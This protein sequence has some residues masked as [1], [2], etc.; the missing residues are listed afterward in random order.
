VTAFLLLAR[1]ASA[2]QAPADPTLP[3]IENAR[4]EYV[5]GKGAETCPDESFFRDMAA[6]HLGGRDPFTPSAP[7][8][9]TLT[10]RRVR[11]GSYGAV[12]ALYDAAGKHLGSMEEFFAPDCFHVVEIA[13]S[14]VVPWVVP[15]FIPK[16]APPA[17]APVC[18]SKPLPAPEPPP[19]RESRF[20]VWPGEWPMRPLRAPRP[21]TP[22]Q[23][24]RWPVA[25]RFGI[26]AGPELIARGLGS[27][28]FSAEIGAR[29]HAVSLN[30]ELHGDPPLGPQLYADG[31]VSF[32]RVSGAALLCGHFGWFAGCGA[33][34]AGRLLFP[35]HGAALPSS[36][37]YG[38]AGVRAGVE[39]PV[40][41]PRLFLRTAFDLRAPIRPA[42]FTYAGVNIFHV[43]GPS[44]G[45]GLGLL[46][47]L[48][49]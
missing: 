8:R 5:L 17:P 38:A 6:A 27:Y 2:Q 44:I 12:L 13:S 22:I 21:D 46:V 40:A 25:V 18:E 24:E 34:D 43:A 35:D 1:G 48:S 33:V 3:P 7:R 26:A 19:C 9:V 11:P 23:L 15:I 14:M 10:V 49:P 28:G 32:A 39:F 45:L 20:S 47:E 16:A 36:A 4:L 41:P 29:Y 31:S 30:A 42:S 37:F